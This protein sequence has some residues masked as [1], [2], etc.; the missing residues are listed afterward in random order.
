MINAT[1]ND[2]TISHISIELSRYCTKGCSFC[3]NG[4]SR[5]QSIQWSVDEA[6]DFLSDCAQHGV[7]SVSFG[8]GEPLEYEGVFEL[9][10]K[11]HPLMGRSITS[12]GLPLRDKGI[13]ESLVKAQPNKVHLSIHNPA[14]YL[15]IARVASQTNQLRQHNIKAG[16]NLL[17]RQSQVNEAKRATQILRQLRIQPEQLILLPMRGQDTPT[18][19]QIA[20]IT[21]GPF[22]SVTCLKQCASSPRF[23]SVGA[24]KTAAWCSYTIQRAHLSALTYHALTQAV[25]SLG[26]TPCSQQL[27]RKKN[28]QST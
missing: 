22:Q 18:P 1:P 17:V 28:R 27:V 7:E 8:G 21:Q 10:N 15:E 24:D 25:Q 6:F 16:I 5:Q 2:T 19:E 13:F 4:S 11:L 20:S 9:L 23:V 14:D 12:N 26:I 3:Y